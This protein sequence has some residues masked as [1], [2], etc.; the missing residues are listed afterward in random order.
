M[1]QDVTTVSWGRRIINALWGIIIGF[2]LII[3]G[4]YLVFWNEGHG[5]H[6]AQSLEQAHKI[7]I[8][9]PSSPID[10]QN[11]MRVVYLSG[12][13]TTSDVLH[14]NVFDVSENAIQLNRHVQMYQ[15]QENKET[16][17]EKQIGGSE[18]EVTNYTYKQEWSSDL[19]DSS[20]FKDQ[21]GHQNPSTMPI[22]SSIHY[23]KTVTVGYFNLPRELI[24][25][26]SGDTSVDLSKV[27]AVELGKKFNKPIHVE[28]EGL[29]MGDD[30]AMPKTGDLRVTITKVLPQ[31]VSIIAQQTGTT[32]Q[33]Y[34]ANAGQPVS[35]LEMGQV[36]SDQMIHNA[37]SQ[38]AI[39]TWILRLASLVMLII[40]FALLMNPIVVL[41]DVIP[42]FGSIVGFGT[43]LVAFICGLLVW[44][45]MVAIA[46]FA[47]RPLF[48]SGLVIVIA[49]FCYLLYAHKKKVTTAQKA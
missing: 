19:I 21:T 6:V 3:G 23:A 24:E 30:S 44:T 10:T 29:Y 2:A 34:M 5:L 47:V 39:M 20:E 48:A 17:T 15:W 7:L 45:A 31:T 22:K 4:I 9:V 35:L 16:K 8:S 14:D 42:F 49:V 32:L 11:N 18:K 12:I 26:I 38:N 28:N 41:A 37:E 27:N 36:S 33:P 40:G 46:W 43:G 1:V 13:A 25:Q